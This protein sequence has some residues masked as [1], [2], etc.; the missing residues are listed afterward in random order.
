LAEDILKKVDIA[1]MLNSLE[2]RVPFLDFRL[3]PLVL[4]LPDKYKIR[5]LKTKWFLKNYAENYIP[6]NIINRKK[7]GFS[8]PLAKWIKEKKMIQNYLTQ[9]KY[10]NHGFINFETTN[11][12]L[13]NLIADKSDYSRTLWLIFVFNLWWAENI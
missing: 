13:R 4:S 11:S 1:S 6:R 10:F 5:G 3:V 8:V 9:K 2:V 7:Q 12:M